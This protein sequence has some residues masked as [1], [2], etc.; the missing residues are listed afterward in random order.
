MSADHINA[1]IDLESNDNEHGFLM[2]DDVHS[3]AWKGVTVNV[4]D[5]QTKK[6]KSIL[7]N[8]SGYVHQGMITFAYIL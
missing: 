2:N 8:V 7:S 5:R 4:K 1:S 6:K 3:F